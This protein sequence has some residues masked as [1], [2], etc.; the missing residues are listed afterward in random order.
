M[1]HHW[2]AGRHA[3]AQDANVKVARWWPRRRF[4]RRAGP[5]GR[6]VAAVGRRA[7]H[8]GRATRVR[9]KSFSYTF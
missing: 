4:A 6:R 3:R 5:F 2:H 8:A 7:L 9:I 1:V